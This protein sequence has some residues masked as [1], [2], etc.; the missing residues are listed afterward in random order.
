MKV[1][2]RAVKGLKKNYIRANHISGGRLELLRLFFP[3]MVLGFIY[4][5]AFSEVNTF[6]LFIG[7]PRSGHTL[8][9]T[10]IDAHPD[11]ICADELDVLQFIRVG[12]RRRQILALILANSRLQAK[13]KVKWSGYSYP[14]PDQFLGRFRQLQAAGSKK[15]ELTS[16]SLHSSP[17]LLRQLPKTMGTELKFIHVTRNPFDNISTM[18]MRNN[19]ELEASVEEYLHLCDCVKKIKEQVDTSRVLDVA[20]ESL[21]SDTKHTLTTLCQFLDLKRIPPDYLETAAELTYD[22]P[23]K[24]RYE[25]EWNKS[26]KRIVQ[27]RMGEYGFLSSYSYN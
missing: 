18:S 15:A 3:S 8:V 23:H 7:Y 22:S 2:G 26:L 21:I 13:T 9:R 4:R 6:F 16:L 24:S 11:A 12:Y 27:R 10:L 14:L 19:R 1:F 20:L 5:K 17:E 25:V